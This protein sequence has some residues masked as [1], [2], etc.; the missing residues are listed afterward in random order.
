IGGSGSAGESPS[1]FGSAIRVVLPR[2]STRRPPRRGG[3]RTWGSVEDKPDRGSFAHLRLAPA[4]RARRTPPRVEGPALGER[5]YSLRVEGLTVGWRA[6]KISAGDS[7]EGVS[8]ASRVFDKLNL[9]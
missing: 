7:G 4:L 9:K 2:H 8:M 5:G 6:S 3:R 1:V